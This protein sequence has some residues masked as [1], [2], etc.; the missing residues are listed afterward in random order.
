MFK[1]EK[2]KIWQESRKFVKDIYDLSRM[3]PQEEKYGLTSQINRSA[4]SITLNIAEGS[5]SGSDKEFRRFLYIASRSLDEVVSCLYL[6]SDMNFTN[7]NKFA[8]L[9]QSAE[10]LGKQISSLKKFL[11]NS[12]PKA[13]SL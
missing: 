1:F 13:I 6:A 3:F 4:V 8:E 12:S 5:N 9:Y 11:N 2:L 10:E 7:Q